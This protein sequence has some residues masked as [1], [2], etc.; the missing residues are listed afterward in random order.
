MKLTKRA[1]DS[2]AYHGN[3]GSAHYLWDDEI[4]GFAVRI[5][6]SGRKSFVIAYRAKG[7]QRFHTIGRFGE[8]TLQEA[9]TE[10]LEKLARIRRGSDPSGER[11]AYSQAPTVADLADRYMR[12][13][14]RLKKKPSIAKDDERSWR[15][16]VL[17]WI[18]KY[19][20]IDATRDDVTGLHTEMAETPYAANRTRSSHASWSAVPVASRYPRSPGSICPRDRPR[21]PRLG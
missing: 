18:G 5:Y 3:T 11:Q 14:A 1:I 19:K 2:T 12:E 13:H 20:V 15:L 16:H 21:A 17:L 10:A 9:R 4:V 6:P 8:L 7:R